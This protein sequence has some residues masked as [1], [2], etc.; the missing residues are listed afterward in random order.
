MRHRQNNYYGVSTTFMLYIFRS[1]CQSKRND[2]N[3][4]CNLKDYS[5]KMLTIF[6]ITKVIVRFELQKREIERL[7]LLIQDF[8]KKK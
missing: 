3:G 2:F 4:R 5:L 6:F 8:L 7:I 1:S